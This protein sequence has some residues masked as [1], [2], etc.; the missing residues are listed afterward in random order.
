MKTNL[1]QLYFQYVHPSIPFLHRSI[2]SKSEKESPSLLLLNAIYAVSS[3]FTKYD[4]RFKQQEEDQ[5]NPP[6]WSYYKMALSLIDLYADR[7]RL[8][9][10]Q[11]LL[12]MA[13]YNEHVYKSGFFWRTKHFIQ[14]AVKMST[15]M[16]LTKEEPF[17]ACNYNSEMKRRTFWAVYTYEVLMR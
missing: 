9:T 6:G 11:A 3:R 10:I 12:L 16:G 4:K 8:S 1:I 14:L 15:D 7:P 17:S 13:K 2:L 5:D